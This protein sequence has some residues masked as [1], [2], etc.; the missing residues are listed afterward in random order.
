MATE[1]G[2]QDDFTIDV[3]RDL[4]RVDGVMTQVL[5]DPAT[6]DEFIRDPSVVLTRLGLHPRTSREVHDRVNRVFYAVLTNADLID[7]ILEHLST[8]E[9][10]GPEDG[11]RLNGGLERG[12]ISH[13]VDFDMAAADHF[14]RDPDALRRVYQLTLHDLNNRRI[15]Q[16]VYAPEEIDEYVDRVVEHI[17]GRGSIRDEPKLEMWDEHYGVGTGYGVGEAE[18]GPVATAV[19]LVEVG[20][21]ISVFIPV[22]FS[23]MK[24]KFENSARGNPESLRALATAGALMRLAGEVMIHANNFERR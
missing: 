12:E 3:R 1:P 23:M 10:A 16:G 15:L 17:Q 2:P 8:W 11:D 5:A 24:P 9:G 4:D 20:A 13:S 14:F 21:A 18:V 22:D 19:A 7:F 6:T